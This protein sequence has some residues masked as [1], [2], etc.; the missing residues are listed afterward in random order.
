MI[1]L[2][3]PFLF[4]VSMFTMAA[5]AIA[6]S[7]TCK[8]AAGRTASRI[9]GGHSISAEEAPYQ[10]RLHVFKG[11]G[12]GGLCGGSLISRSYVLTAAH[13]VVDK[14]KGK[15]SAGWTKASSIEVWFGGDDVDA[16]IDAQTGM[17]V[18]EIHVHPEYNGK[19]GNS[20]IA[21]LRLTRPIAVPQKAIITLASPEMDTAL[22]KDHTCARVT[23]YGRT[24][25][26]GDTSDQML[27]V[28]LRIQPDATCR[29]F[30]KSF[31]NAKF[32]DRIVCAGYPS[33]DK[34]S[35][36]GDSGGPLVINEGPTGWVQVG[37]VA[38][39]APGCT[40]VGNYGVYTRVSSFIPWVLEVAK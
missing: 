4:G 12:G 33:G 11:E 18:S 29:K 23:G 20:D 25:G 8:D 37:V 2:L 27:G 5:P 3:K 38:W 7:F 36:R 19:D 22:V 24:S 32:N 14:S 21:V 15:T 26:D 17:T 9:I 39:G 35:C 10:V 1:K 31:R 13:C 16:M 28:N 30:V 34:S 6:E 40:G